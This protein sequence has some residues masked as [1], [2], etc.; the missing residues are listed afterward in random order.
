MAD[1]IRWTTRNARED[2]VNLTGKVTLACKDEIVKRM[3]VADSKQAIELGKTV[4]TG[5]LRT[6]AAEHFLSCT[7]KKSK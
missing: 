4:L 5:E 3:V 7:K 2:W 1:G 6:A